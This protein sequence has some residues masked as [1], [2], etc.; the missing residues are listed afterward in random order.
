MMISRVAKTFARGWL[1][2]LALLLPL[3]TVAHAQER[4]VQ[5]DSVIDVRGDGSLDITENIRV[6]A[7]GSNIRRGIY[8]DFPTRYK[9]RFGNRVVVD[10]SVLGVQRDGTAE[11]WFTERVDNGVRVNTGNDDFLSVPADYTYTL[12]Y[13]TT[14]QLGFFADHDELYFNAIGTG[15]DF[16]IERGTVE[17]RLPQPVPVAQMAAE[18]YTGQAGSKGQ[19]YDAKLIAPGIARWTLTQPLSPGEG[20]TIVLSFPK[21]IVAIPSRAQRLMWLLKDNS[22]VLIA[23]AGLALLLLYCIR[24]WRA[25]GRDPR[26]GVVVVRYDPPQDHSPADLRFVQK[27]GY[28]NRCFSSELLACA[29]DGDL[30]I[31]REDRPGKDAWQ[32]QR[33][34]ATATASS[35]EQRALLDTLFPGKAAELVLDNSNA[36][37]I[38]VAMAAHT[39][40][41]DKRFNH[42]MFNRNGGSIGIAVMIAIASIALAIGIGAG[43]LGS[44]LILMLPVVVLMIP[45]LIVFGIAIKAPTAE[46]RALLD[47]IEGFKRY[48]GVAERDELARMPGP[49][50]PPV[51]DAKRYEHLLPY[52]V[53]L[54]VEDAWTKK[55]TLAVG[56]AAAAAATAAITWY[57]SSNAGDLGSLSRA[58]GSSLTSQIAS[59]STPPGSSSG[60]GGGGSSGGGGGGG[61]GGGR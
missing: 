56:A 4:I 20:M 44:G 50:A 26:A 29:V 13:R 25:V 35:A 3:A 5:Y 9:D 24:R 2:A 49:D 45:V 55:F 59:S 48:L 18:A 42:R 54:E 33:T 58:I 34:A 40:L 36:S 31:H 57:H 43:L 30:R 14:R 39:K 51:L 8:R 60:G 52:A 32:L 17:V 38:R 1:L 7:E 27:M 37:I 15:W 12:H 53:A 61:G 28:D 46:G 19:A 16:A 41:L 11:P 23:L 22:A 6:H 21:G 10:F 47:A